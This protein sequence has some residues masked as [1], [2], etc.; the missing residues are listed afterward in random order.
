VIIQF[1]P[2][3]AVEGYRKSFDMKSKGQFGF[4]IIP[5]SILDHST[6]S[7][8]LSFVFSTF[9][10]H[11]FLQYLCSKNTQQQVIAVENS[12]DRTTVLFISRK[13]LDCLEY[14]IE[15]VVMSD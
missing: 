6:C 14:N 10:G 2:L 15:S 5:T 4:L 3:A 8:V 11:V 9:E 12:A 1:T 7:Q 13:S